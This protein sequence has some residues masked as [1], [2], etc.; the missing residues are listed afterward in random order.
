MDVAERRPRR[1]H[2]TGRLRRR[3]HVIKQQINLFV[4]FE[5]AASDV[6]DRCQLSSGWAYSSTPKGTVIDF[7][8]I[9]R[10]GRPS[11]A[12]SLRWC[13]HRRNEGISL[14]ERAVIEIGS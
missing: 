5:V 3:L 12:S 2:R 1:R 13:Q 11:P 8:L 9:G 10:A 14:L 6:V 7:M 4:L